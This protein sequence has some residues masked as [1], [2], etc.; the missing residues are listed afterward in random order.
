[1]SGSSASDVILIRHAQSQW[2]LENRFSGWADP[3]LTPAGEQEAQ[4]AGSLLKQLGYRFDLAYTSRLRRAITT[5]DLILTAMQHPEIPVHRDWRL[6]E[7]HYG[8]LQG[9]LKTPEAHKTTPEQIWRWRRSYMDKADVLDEN[10]PRHPRHSE[11]Y[12]DL[13]PRLLPGVEN[14]AECRVRIEA[15]WQER[16]VPDLAANK[17]VLISAHGNSLRALLMALADMS[18]EEVE[19]FEIPTGIPI[20]LSLDG[21]GRLREWYYLEAEGTP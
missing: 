11:L 3:P 20:R 2:N 14:L 18:V 5:L 12:R 4:A 15:F 6:N 9:T 13:D 21:Q 7:R 17:N 19:Q 8:Q 1:M 10:D 16:V